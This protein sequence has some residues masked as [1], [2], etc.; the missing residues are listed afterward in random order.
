[1]ARRSSSSSITYKWPYDVFLSFY[2][3]DTRLGF[4]SHLYESLRRSGIHAFIDNKIRDGEHI[5]PA[6]FKAIEESR[7]A[8][9]VFSE[10]YANSTFCLQELEKIVDCF[11]EESRLI[12]PVFYYVDPSELRRPKGSYA[13]ALA[14][15]EERFK[16]ERHKVEKWRQALSQAAAH[17]GCHLESKIANEQECITRI[18]RE[19]AV[20]INIK[21]L[22]VTNYPVGLESRVKEV[23]SCLDLWSTEEIKMI[24]IWGAGGIGKSTIARAVYN[25]I[26]HD[27]EGSCF[28]SDVR[29]Q[30]KMPNG[31]SDLQEKLL[32]RLVME[33]DLKLGDYHEGIPIIEHRLSQKKILLILDD[34]DESNQLKVVAGSC[35]W[36]GHGSRII[37]TTRNKQLLKSHGIKSIY[38]V[39][40]LNGE[41]SLKL[42][43]WYAFKKENVDSN[44]MKVCKRATHYCCGFPL[45]LE[46]IGSYLYGKEVSQWSSALDQFKSIPDRTVLNALKLSFDTLE[47][48]EKQVFLDLACFFNEDLGKDIVRQESPYEPGERSRLW[49]YQDIIHVLQQDTGTNKVEAM[50]LDLLECIE[51]QWS[52][53]EL[54]KMKNLK[55]LVI[56]NTCFSESPK[57]LPNSLRWLEW[58]G[59]PFKSLPHQVRPTQLAYLDLSYSSCEFLQPFDKKFPNLSHMD[60]RNCKFL[61]QIPDLSGASNLTELWVDG[62]TNLIEIHDSVGCLNKLRELSAV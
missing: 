22:D 44:Y 24:G 51:V 29:K 3:D 15:L 58:K 12:Y 20:R 1:M 8:I 19:V 38:D 32:G 18:T 62:C 42:L 10:N 57:D 46:V 34:V 30:S 36:F 45:V 35:D 40:L 56:R 50:I 28:L 5:T 9:I 21:P 2:G 54:M 59:Y 14:R 27:F 16:S 55:L 31:L 47:E 43:T 49:F 4:I 11:K 7:I 61:Q 26:A 23:I 48:V 60:L 41:E 13:E 39:K 52:G 6:L 37:I 25:L 17:K 53:E 33:K